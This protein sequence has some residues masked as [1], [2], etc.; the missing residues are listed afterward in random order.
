MRYVLFSLFLILAFAGVS[1]AAA[2]DVTV[3]I[4]GTAN[5]RVAKMYNKTK[6]DQNRIIMPGVPVIDAIEVHAVTTTWTF[7]NSGLAFWEI[8]S[9]V[10]AYVYIGNDLTNGWY[11]PAGGTLGSGVR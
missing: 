3:T 2:T 4:T 9:P 11:I 6:Y 10:D 7:S 5:I 1:C 8:Y